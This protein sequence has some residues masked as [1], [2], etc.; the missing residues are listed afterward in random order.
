MDAATWDDRYSGRDLVWSAG[1]NFFVEQLCADLPPGSAVDLAAG[2]GR[3]ALWLAER[4]WTA[5]AVDFSSVALQRAQALAEE[6]LGEDIDRFSTEV[7]DLAAWAPPTEGFGLVV[8]AYLQV[9]ADQ[10]RPMLATAARAVAPGGRLL[11]IAH[12][13]AN[14][15]RGVGGPPDPAV[16]YT[17]A[18]VLAD[19]DGSG[20]AI[21][22][23][24][25]VTR[26]VDTPEGV[27]HAIDT[28]VWAC[29]K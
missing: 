28:L 22:R 3:N 5:L 27:K 7:A 1:P 23:A 12:H 9:P 14:I 16:N 10:R 8:V 29:R 25:E 19:I 15:E 20:L 4:G 26:P 6:R 13:P 18:D 21:D 11:V 17:E 24:E 2:E